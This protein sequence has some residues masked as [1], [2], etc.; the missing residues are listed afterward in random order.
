MTRIPA[1]SALHLQHAP[2]IQRK[3]LRTFEI[4]VPLLP[5]QVTPFLL[6][7]R[8]VE[9]GQLPQLILLVNVLLIVDDHEHLRDH[10]GRRID[11]R[12]IVPGDHH[13]EGFVL[14][15]GELR[16][17]VLGE[18]TLGPLLDGAL[19]PNGD[20]APRLGLHVLLGLAPRPDDETDEVVRGVLIHRNGY[21]AGALPLGDSGEGGLHGGAEL[22]DAFEADEALFGVAFLPA[23]GAGV[24][25]VAVG[26]V[27]GGRGGGAGGVVAGEGVHADGFGGE[28]GEDAVGFAEAGLEGGQLGLLVCGE[29]GGEEGG[30]AGGG[31]GWS[32]GGEGGEAEGCHDGVVDGGRGWGVDGWFGGVVAASSPTG[33][34]L[35]G[36]RD[37]C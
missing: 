36:G 10:L 11:G 19:P 6:L 32:G 3:L 12:R 27:D 21:L 15:L 33:F 8:P 14:P 35:A 31:G 7:Q 20:L 5:A 1:N 34:A 23:V 22:G 4:S 2:I 28:V 9:Q 17:P 18:T 29:V 30:E 13:V 25:A 16:R 37:G 24:L 26:V